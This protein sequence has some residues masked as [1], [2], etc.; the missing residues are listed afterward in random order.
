M[1]AKYGKTAAAIFALFPFPKCEK[2]FILSQ[3]LRYN[4]FIEC[5]F[6]GECNPW[7]LLL[8]EILLCITFLYFNIGRL[9][10]KCIQICST[11]IHP[12][13]HIFL[14]IKNVSETSAVQC[15]QCTIRGKVF[16]EVQHLKVAGF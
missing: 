10:N 16:V 4:L 6:Y 7:P 2:L 11:E 8:L 12:F 14:S 15:T 5:N 3:K 13:F 1:R 9:I